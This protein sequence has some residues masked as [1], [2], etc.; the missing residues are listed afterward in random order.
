MRRLTFDE[1]IEERGSFDETVRRTPETATFC[2]CA[3]WQLAAHTTMQ[4]PEPE[5]EYFIFEDEG[6]WVVFAERGGRRVFYPLEAAWMFGSPLI[7]DPLH[8]LDLLRRASQ[9]HL[10]SPYGFC[11]GGLLRGGRLHRA[12]LSRQDECLQFEEFDATDC[13]EIDLAEGVEAWLERRSKRFRKAVRKRKL[14]DDIEIIDA[15]DIYAEEIFERIVAI[16]QET[17]KWREGS[18]IFQGESYRRFYRTLLDLLHPDGNHRVLFARRGDE[19]LAYIFGG[20]S[21]G[22]YRG[23]QMSYVETVKELELGNILQVENLRRRAEEGMKKYDLGMY[24]EYKERW[25][26]RHDEYCGVFMVW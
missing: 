10:E 13:M 1:F 17:Y 14:P 9:K 6:N 5:D 12:I 18:D 22:I 7:G 19:D 4:R 11:F 2:S 24:S 16:Q 21:G 8:A 15:Q 3:L 20:I 25:A 26:D 23:F